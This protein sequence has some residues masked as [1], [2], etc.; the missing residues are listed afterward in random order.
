MKRYL[1]VPVYVLMV[2]LSGVLV[3]AVGYRLYN[4]KSVTATAAPKLKP[5][6]IRRH[7][8]EDMRTRL[9]LSDV[10]VTELQAALDATRQSFAEYD[11]RSKAQRKAIIEEQHNKVRAFLRPDQRQDYENY[12]AERARRRAEARANSTKK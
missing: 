11:Q 3:G 4:A 10:Q 6:E 9:R 8:V 5:E 12:L 1:A 2:F 7:I